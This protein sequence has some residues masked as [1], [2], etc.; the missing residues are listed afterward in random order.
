MTKRTNCHK[1]ISKH[2]PL[3]LM[4]NDILSRMVRRDSILEKQEEIKIK[5]SWIKIVA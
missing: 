1:H 2:R 5:K 4:T 3:P